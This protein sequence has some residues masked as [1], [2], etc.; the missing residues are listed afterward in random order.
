MDAKLNSTSNE[1]PLGILL[2]DS[3]TQKTRNTW[4]N[5]M[6]TFLVFGAARPFKSML[7]RYLLDAEFNFASNE[8]SR[9][10]F[11]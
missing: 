8:L 11:E 5:V 9:S 3:A 7:S 4:I 6:M 1:Y 10:K 2:K